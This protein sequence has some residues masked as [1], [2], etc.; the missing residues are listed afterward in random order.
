VN[1]FNK[2][3]WEIDPARSALLL[4]DIKA[5][6]LAPLPARERAALCAEAERLARLCAARG[7]PVF[8]C[9][10]A[11][12]GPLGPEGPLHEMR[13]R[14]VQSASPA[15]RLEGLGV[16]EVARRGY[17]AFFGSDLEEALRRA[18]RDSLVLAGLHTSIG[19]LSTAIDAL[20][21]DIRPV[22]VADVMADISLAEHEAGLMK[23]AESGARIVEMSDL[24]EAMSAPRRLPAAW[25]F[26][27]C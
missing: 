19:C 11:P 10:M 26:D 1:V 7:M 15:P 21:R 14:S 13:P 23:A 24:V 2:V 27:V 3:D 8:V 20:R 6:H 25:A 9:E 4:Q 22:M 16:R 17:S 12:G 18:R 5:P